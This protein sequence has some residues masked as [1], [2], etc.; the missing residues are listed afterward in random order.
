MK[1]SFILYTKFSEIIEE[2]TDEQAGQILKALFAYSV[3]NEEPNFTG[4]LKFA[5]IPI[6]QQLDRNNEK[7]R[8][9]VAKNRAN[10]A[11][12]GRPP[13]NK[14]RAD[15]EK[16]NGLQKNQTDNKETEIKP[17]KPSGLNKNQ[18]DNE[19][20][21]GL[22]KN[23]TDKT[24]TLHEYEHEY[25]HENEN[26]TA[27][28]GARA[29]EAVAAVDFE[30]QKEE[31]LKFWNSNCQN[32]PKAEKLTPKRRAALQNLLT[33]GYTPD[34]IA[35]CMLIAN[36]TPTLNGQSLT[37]R[38]KRFCASFDWVIDEN[39]FVT[40]YEQRGTMPSQTDAERRANAERLRLKLDEINRLFLEKEAK[41]KAKIY[42]EMTAEKGENF[43]F[44]E[45]E[46]R[47]KEELK[48]YRES[49]K[50]KIAELKAKVYADAGENPN[51]DECEEKAVNL[52][53]KLLQNG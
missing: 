47:V 15:N 41:L 17:Q 42:D 48:A 1:D 40:L 33:T 9:Q 51:E 37:T 21:S 44:K 30:I 16:P 18:A 36:N 45:Y 6:R 53:L 24:K 39:N 43:E 8:E 7:W 20:P 5:W 3:S 50:Q 49:E 13:K 35:D 28:A 23:Q 10:G 4:I 19:K 2:L 34:E 46:N 38:G 32:L 22:Q 12:G 11:L 14:N 52:I 26:A 27:N 29:R 25:E 31:I